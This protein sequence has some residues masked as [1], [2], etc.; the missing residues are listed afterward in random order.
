MFRQAPHSFLPAEVLLEL[1][2]RISLMSFACPARDQ[3]CSIIEAERTILLHHSNIHAF[4][5]SVSLFL[6][7]RP[8]RAT[9]TRPSTLAPHAD[10]GMVNPVVPLTLRPAVPYV[11]AAGAHELSMLATHDTSVV[12]ALRVLWCLK[13]LRRQSLFL[14]RRLTCQRRC[15]GNRLVTGSHHV[16]FFRHLMYDW[17]L[18]GRFLGRRLPP[19]HS[20]TCS[21]AATLLLLLLLGATPRRLSRI[22]AVLRHLKSILFVETFRVVAPGG[23]AHRGI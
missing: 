2:K 10:A 23:V 15:M 8:R 20:S 3:F 18:A 22:K 21:L 1:Y 17:F 7:V 16:P 13:C 4:S 14:W 11:L 9:A 12:L 5:F 19:E 6:S